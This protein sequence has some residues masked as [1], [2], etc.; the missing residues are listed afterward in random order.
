MSLKQKIVK[1]K[2]SF[3]NLNKSFI[4]LTFFFISAVLATPTFANLES[5]MSSYRDPSPFYIPANLSAPV[6]NITP[7]YSAYSVL[8]E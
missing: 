5:P 2:I 1:N 3:L 8:A 6:N 4:P 7:V